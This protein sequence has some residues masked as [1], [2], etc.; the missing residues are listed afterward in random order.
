MF[1]R[2]GLK[3]FVIVG[4]VVFSAR[5]SPKISGEEPTS[6]KR[7]WSCHVLDQLSYCVY[8]NSLCL[9][10]NSALV[11]VTEDGAKH[12]QPVELLNDLGPGPWHFLDLKNIW[13]SAYGRYDV[14]FRSFF[15][16]AKYGSRLPAGAEFRKGWS[17]VAAFDSDGHNIYHYVNTMHAAFIARLYE[18]GGLKERSTV[19]DVSAN[20]LQHMKSTESQIDFAY[21]YRPPP[22]SWQK[23][24]GEISLG[25]KTKFFYVSTENKAKLVP[26]CF[27]RAIIP[28]AAL[29]LADGLASSMLF[30]EL[31]ATIKGIRVQESERNLITI[32]GERSKGDRGIINRQEFTDA[33]KS[34][35]PQ[36]EV[37]TTEWDGTTDFRTQALHMA[38]TRVLIT[39]HGSVLNHAIFMEAAGVVIELVGFQFH[40]PVVE[41]VI[42]SRGNHYIRYEESLENTRPKSLSLGVDPFPDFST[43]Q[44]MAE[45][46]C[47]QARRDADLNINVSN[48][49]VYFQQALS[50]VV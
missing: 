7:G 39:T 21:L 44:C 34:M 2:R 18:L 4:V 17:L 28:G 33:V 45:I 27:E 5:L 37:V 50:L 46:S 47:L 41:V 29:Y 49:S 31:A 10:E 32:I 48:F 38:R 11:L 22:T 25:N 36:M 42:S 9:N 40:Y 30:R 8:H 1:C 14:P 24:Y 3:L 19:A 16:D 15:K 43:R 12:N 6:Q 13:R 26:V 35:A 20:I 23:N